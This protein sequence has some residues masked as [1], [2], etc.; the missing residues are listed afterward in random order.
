[1]AQE[2]QDPLNLARCY[3]VVVMTWV[4]SGQAQSIEG[5]LTLDSLDI[6]TERARSRDPV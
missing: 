6:S 5:H 1:M 2:R 3:V 4:I